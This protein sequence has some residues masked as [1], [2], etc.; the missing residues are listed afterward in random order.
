MVGQPA[1]GVG[2]ARQSEVGAVGQDSG[3]QGGLVGCGL[4]GAQ[5]G[6]AVGEPGQPSTSAST[7]VMR[8]RGSMPYSLAASGRAASGTLGFMRAI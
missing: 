1:R 5:V 4:A 2:H 3:Q 7:S 8:A 6:E